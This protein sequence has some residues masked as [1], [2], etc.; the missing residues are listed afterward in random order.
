MTMG[1]SNTYQFGPFRLDAADV[2]N[3][4]EPN[5]PSLNITG[6]A[7]TNFG[8]ISGKSNLHRQLQAQLRFSF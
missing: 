4:P 3:H 5:S 7:A 1:G 2:L 8:L 6:A